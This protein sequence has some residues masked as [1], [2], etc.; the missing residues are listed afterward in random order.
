MSLWG[1]RTRST[2]FCEVPRRVLVEVRDEDAL[3]KAAGDASEGDGAEVGYVGSGTW[4]ATC[5]GTELGMGEGVG[6]ESGCH[7]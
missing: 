2:I 1:S 6:D 4:E 5:E 7:C 3:T